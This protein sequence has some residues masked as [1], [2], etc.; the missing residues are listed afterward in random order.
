MA[1][2]VLAILGIVFITMSM[3]AGCEKSLASPNYNSP[4]IVVKTYFNAVAKGD[5]KTAIACMGVVWEDQY[6]SYYPS[7]DDLK[8][9]G[10]EKVDVK[11]K[12]YED[13]TGEDYQQAMRSVQQDWLNDG[14]FTF[15]YYYSD[16]KR[17]GLVE[18]EISINGENQGGNWIGV[19]ETNKGWFIVQ[20]DMY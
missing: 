15:N 10:I 6:S 20:I 4:E 8:E 2:R 1:K 3:L 12:V 17:I 13:W 9:N 11:V 16:I 19:V 7:K 5:A 18:Y 14:T